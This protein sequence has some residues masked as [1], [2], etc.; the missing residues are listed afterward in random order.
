MNFR[1]GHGLIWVNFEVE[2]AQKVYQIKDCIIDT[3]SA[4][5]A[6]H[7]DAVEFDLRRGGILKRL[8]GI[9]GGRQEVVT[10]MVDR[11]IIDKTE[12]NQIEIEFGNLQDEFGVNGF[13]GNDILKHFVVAID[14]P[15]QQIDF[16]F[17]E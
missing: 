9:G 13:V 2:Y 14:Y 7:T 5:T 3:G 16:T 10:Q 11:F 12:F 4:T 1:W 17:V 8:V 15:R 6:V